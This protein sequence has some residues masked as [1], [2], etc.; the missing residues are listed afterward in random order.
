MYCA[1]PDLQSTSLWFKKLENISSSTS[2]AQLLPQEAKSN[3]FTFL[4]SA[5][6]KL[7]TSLPAAP[8]APWI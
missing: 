8:P 2:F 5:E 6:N 7:L 4:D 1:V 3:K